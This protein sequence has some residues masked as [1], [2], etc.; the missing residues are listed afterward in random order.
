MNI[1]DI[2]DT[3]EEKLKQLSVAELVSLIVTCQIHIKFTNDLDDKAQLLDFI[4]EVETLALSK[5]PKLSALKAGDYDSRFGICIGVLD[6]YSA[7]LDIDNV[8]E[9]PLNLK[10]AT[11]T[12]ER[13][14]RYD[15]PTLQETKLIVDNINIINDAL[16][17]KANNH[18]LDTKRKHKSSVQSVWLHE[19]IHND[20]WGKIAE[21]TSTMWF[22]SSN[23]KA[24][25]MPIRRLMEDDL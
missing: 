9:K 13:T 22:G 10:K 4:K 20:Y 11:E 15:F 24:I 8:S 17:T 23:G 3:T 1:P 19:T 7:W 12:I 2:I 14:A 25:V 18:V 21:L 5:Q 16:V 6:N